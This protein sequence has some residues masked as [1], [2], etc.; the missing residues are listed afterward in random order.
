MYELKETYR[1]SSDK[2]ILVLLGSNDTSDV[3]TVS[4]CNHT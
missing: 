1:S 4:L 2:I 3:G